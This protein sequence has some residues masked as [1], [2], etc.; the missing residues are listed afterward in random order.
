MPFY[1]PWL[2]WPITIQRGKKI[3]TVYVDAPVDKSSAK[4][5]PNSDK[6]VSRSKGAAKTVD[7]NPEADI[8]EVIDGFFKVLENEKI[9]NFEVKQS[10][11]KSLEKLTLTLT[12]EQKEE[13]ADRLLQLLLKEKSPGVRNEI[14]GALHE[15]YKKDTNV[16]E[17]NI[18]ML[19]NKCLEEKWL[20]DNEIARAIVKDIAGELSEG[21]RKKLCDALLDDKCTLE[22]TKYELLAHLAK[23]ASEKLQDRIIE[24]F[25]KN[26]KNPESR[27]QLHKLAK[28]INPESAA[29]LADLLIEAY[30][31]IK[32]PETLNSKS[33]YKWSLDGNITPYRMLLP[34]PS[35]KRNSNAY[36][37]VL[38]TLSSQK[39]RLDLQTK[40]E[41][42]LKEH[43]LFTQ[44]EIEYYRPKK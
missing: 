30:Q 31:Y 13:T 29:P 7:T 37:S 23:G 40:L 32:P 19:K 44:K 9:T 41:N 2:L 16:F 20:H 5:G 1:W 6:F 10:V 36:E 8:Q 15:T 34:Q 17:R 12:K 28:N 3:E 33:I 43:K 24:E 27:Y 26:I 21:S 35:D 14:Y 18:E 22:G 25:K 4:D 42:I 38:K 39:N 11:I